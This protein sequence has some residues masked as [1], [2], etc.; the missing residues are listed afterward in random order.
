VGEALKRLG[1]L[2]TMVWDT[3]VGRDPA[4]PPLDEWGG[5]GYALAAL[6]AALPGGWEIVPL[7]KVGRDLAPQAQR[8]LRDLERAAPQARFVEVPEPNP[9]VKLRYQTEG[10]RCEG[11]RGGVPPWTWAE[12]G[13]MVADLDA[14]YVNFITGFEATLETMQALRRGFDRPLYGDL[15]SLSL[16]IRADGLRH[17]RPLEEPLAWLLCFD[18]VQ[19]NEDEMGQLGPEPLALAVAALER[20]VRAVAVTLGSRGAVY[21]AARTSAVFGAPAAAPPPQE[22]RLV[23]TALVPTDGGP[24]EGDP[25]GC[26]DVFGATLMSGLLGGSDLD[27]AVA[28]A[29]RAARRNV[30][31]RGASGLQHFLR[32]NL[33]PA[34]A[35]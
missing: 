14:L 6:D 28:A 31:Y 23:R 21:V 20:G 26:G 13:P 25:T 17:L 33:A 35:S 32:G 8:F 15:H 29:N 10:R 7:V 9:R 34:P 2:G 4:E 24:A 1:V 18:V 30:T 5:I 12:L 19:S 22:A 27:S 3:I 16:G 11:L